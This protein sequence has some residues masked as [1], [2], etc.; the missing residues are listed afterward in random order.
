MFLEYYQ[1]IKYVFSTVLQL[2]IN[3]CSFSKRIL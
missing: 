3:N 1:E 2:D